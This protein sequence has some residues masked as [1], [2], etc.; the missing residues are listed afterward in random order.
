MVYH[1]IGAA[2]TREGIEP[3]KPHVHS[4]GESELC[5]V[6]S[7]QENSISMCAKHESHF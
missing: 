3:S 1:Q 2:H 4:L 5:L 7:A 6:P